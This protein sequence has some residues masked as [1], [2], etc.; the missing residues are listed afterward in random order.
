MQV[1][2]RRAWI[3]MMFVLVVVAF[4]IFLI[5]VSASNYLIAVILGLLVIFGIYMIV[6][7]FATITIDKE[8]IILRQIWGA[9]YEMAWREV[10]KVRFSDAHIKFTGKDK[11][12]TV[13]LDGVCAKNELVSYVADQIEARRLPTQPLTGLVYFRRFRNCRVA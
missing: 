5:S 8:K 1:Q 7:S 4:F 3:A 9:K 11:W 12:L 10:E 6:P 13:T 2:Y